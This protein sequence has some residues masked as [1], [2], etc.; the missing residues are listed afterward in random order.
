MSKTPIE[1]TLYDEESV[2]IKTYKQRHITFDMLM[3]A[4]KLEELLSGEDNNAET[5]AKKKMWWWLPWVKEEEPKNETAQQ[6]DALMEFV[7]TFFMDQFTPD[8]LRKGA[9]VSEVMTV[10][11]AIM[12]R[13]GRIVETNPTKPSP[14]KKA[15]K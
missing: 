13:A 14:K 11:H 2:P 15:K 1:I 5:P 6:I 9:D 8:E 4:T 10:I 7:S 12:G 3:E